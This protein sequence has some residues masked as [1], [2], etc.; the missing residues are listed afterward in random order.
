[1]RRLGVAAL[2]LIPAALDAQGVRGSVADAGGVPIPGVVVQLIGADSGIAARALT[3]AEGRFLVVAQRAGTYR[4]RTLRIG[5]RPVTSE[6][7]ALGAGQ[8]VPRQVAMAA[9]SLGLDT[10]RVGGRNA[11]GQAANAGTMTLALYEQARAAITATS[12]SGIQRGVTARRVV[13]TQLFDAAG[14]RTVSASSDVFTQPLAQP[15]PSEPPENLHRYGYIVVDPDSTAYRAPGLDML[16]SSYFFEDHCF[17]LT[18]GREDSELGIEFTPTA[19]RKKLAD[20]RGT[21][22]M[23]RATAQLKRIEFRYSNPENPDLESGARGE[24]DFVRLATGA[25]GVA[26][27]SIRMPVLAIGVNATRGFGVAAGAE[28]RV[29]IVNIR[30]SGGELAL[31]TAGAD[32]LYARPPLTLTGTVTDSATGRDVAGARLELAGTALVATS[33]RN[34]R[35]S[36][37]GVLPGEYTLNVRTPALDSLGI[38]NEMAVSVTDGKT[39]LRVRVPTAQQIVAA[40]C[41]AARARTEIP[42]IVVGAV[43]GRDGAAAPPN[44]RVTVEWNDITTGDARSADVRADDSGNFRVCGVALHAPLVMRAVADS[45]ASA[46][47][48][49]AVSADQRMARVELVLDRAAGASGVL[50]GAVVD[51]AGNAVIGAEVTLPDL[52]LSRPS[53]GRGAFRI[54]EIPAGKH[55]V[56]VR[57]LGFGPMNAELEFATFET[58]QRRVVL[59]RVTTLDEVRVT[60]TMYDRLMTEFDA[61][62]KVGLGTFFSPEFLRANET[63]KLSDLLIGANGVKIQPSG[64]N[65]AIAV[66]SRRCLD[67]SSPLCI[68]CPMAVYLDGVLFDRWETQDINQFSLTGLEAVEVYAGRAQAPAKY[69]GLREHCGVIVIHTRRD[70]GKK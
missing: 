51:S 9:V 64:M 16:A 33:E 54:G 29:R 14:F 63:R 58:L 34:G 39:P 3:D 52:G 45:L 43:H 11:C 62:R 19:E 1:M 47:V 42:G 53:D 67:Y 36:M 44:A 2:A 70:F 23:D 50:M 57:K 10:V 65:K 24:I 37:T 22:W 6:P 13:Y 12:I 38:G 68:P 35:F 15:W 5:F 61:N 69:A 31:V 27:W 66:S 26:K 46:P 20:I 40:F 21:M 59:N 25:W 48:A 56:V 8:E 7:I 17:R 30:Q 60:A 32:T 28:S 41:G 18:K 55:K 4:V 49:T